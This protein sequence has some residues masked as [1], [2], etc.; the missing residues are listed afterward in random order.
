M[1]L[2]ADIVSPIPKDFKSDANIARRAIFKR[3]SCSEFLMFCFET[4]EVGIWSS[5]TQKNVERVIDFLL[6]GFKGSFI[7]LLGCYP[8]HQYRI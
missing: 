6:G 5:R 4:F 1:G 7:V 3:P 2:L 8:V